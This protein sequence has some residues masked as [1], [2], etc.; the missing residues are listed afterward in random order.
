MVG[1]KFEVVVAVICDVCCVTVV[2]VAISS[3]TVSVQLVVTVV[4]S[5]PPLSV[6]SVLVTT[7]VKVLEVTVPPLGPVSPTLYCCV[8]DSAGLE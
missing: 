4:S 1:T 6:T 2:D 5:K 7:E 3:T 8:Y